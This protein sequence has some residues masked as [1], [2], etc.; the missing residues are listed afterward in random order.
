MAIPVGKLKVGVPPTEE[1]EGSWVTS[2]ARTPCSI[3]HLRLLAC[4]HGTGGSGCLFNISRASVILSC[5]EMQSCE[6]VHT[7]FCKKVQRRGIK[8]SWLKM[9]TSPNL[10]TYVYSKQRILVKGPSATQLPADGVNNSAF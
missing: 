4:V 9:Q 2:T 6:K 7:Q 5:G 3:I 1:D 8:L 10:D